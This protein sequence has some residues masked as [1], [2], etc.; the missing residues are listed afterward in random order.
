MRRVGYD[1]T[2]QTWDVFLSHSS[3]DKDAVRVLRKRLGDA[4]VK[5]W[6]DEEQILPGHSIPLQIEQG[7]EHSKVV[8]LCLSP[9]FL[10][11]EW[12][13]AERAAFTYADPRF[14][15][16]TMIPVILEDCAV[17]RTLA[18]I[19]AVDYRTRTKEA[20]RT[21]IDALTAPLM[22]LSLPITPPPRGKP[23]GR[24][25]KSPPYI[26]QEGITLEQ[27]LAERAAFQVDLTRAVLAEAL[28]RCNGEV[29][30]LLVA[31]LDG[32]TNINE[33][34]GIATGEFVIGAV[35]RAIEEWAKRI[36]LDGTATSAAV[37]RAQDEWFV[38]LGAPVHVANAAKDLSESIRTVDYEQITPGLFVSACVGFVNVQEGK[39]ILTEM[40]RALYGLRA[41]KRKGSGSVERGPLAIKAAFNDA[42]EV[43][44]VVELTSSHLSHGYRISWAGSSGYY[45]SPVY[46][47]D[48]APVPQP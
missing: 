25:V 48:V 27:T 36:T 32:F 41:A 38:L 4:G 34:Y 35:D 46:F 11:S 10:E 1:D 13:P 17:P 44:E 42:R 6:F 8:V 39:S 22:G 23:E 30:M 2:V 5:V 26:P 12:T 21:L 43:V 33:A 19:R 14:K 3:R 40:R 15:R 45:C 47:G 18:H 24:G 31:D 16:R 29:K 37:S 28:V 9:S 7:I 20:A